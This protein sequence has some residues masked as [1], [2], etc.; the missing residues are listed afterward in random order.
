MKSINLEARPGCALCK[1]VN[2]TVHIPFTEIP[3][4]RCAAC[5][6]IYSS[7][8]MSD[9][10]LDTYYSNE[11]GGLR[12][13]Q[14]QI[15]NARVNAVV[16]NRILKMNP[17]WKV[18]DIGT[19]YGFL[20]KEFRVRHGIDGVGI[21]LS[22]QEAEYGN[23]TLGLNILTQHLSDSGLTPESFDLVVACEVIEHTLDPIRFLEEMKPFVRR[24]GRIIIFTDNFE[25]SVVRSLGA[26]WP[27]WIPHTHVSHFAPASLSRAIEQAGYRVEIKAS[28]T[29]WEHAARDLKCKLLGQITKPEEGF[30]LNQALGTEMTRG[31]AAFELRK[32]FNP[33]WTNLTLRKDLEGAMMCIVASP[34]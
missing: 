4:V 6:F 9:E 34:L 11:F 30:D 32:A 27:K 12:H 20:L 2:S 17:S 18:L 1:S 24:N 19:G 21:E 29:P 14:G 3:V 15:V 31:Y 5:G 8:V 25:S 7:K 10:A 26:G 16:L 23:K 13:L 22:K 33:I 28:F